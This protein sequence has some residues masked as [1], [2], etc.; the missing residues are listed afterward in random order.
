MGPA[1]WADP[2]KQGHGY[3]RYFIIN[4]TGKVESFEELGGSADEDLDEWH[5]YKIAIRPDRYVEF[6]K[7]GEPI[8]KT[9]SK[10]SLDYTNMPL[11][12]G[13]RS[14]SSYG[15]A[16][17]DN[18]RV[19]AWNIITL[20]PIA[21]FTY[22]P[23]KPV[24][25]QPVI[26]DASRSYDPDGGNITEYWWN[27]SGTVYTAK[28]FNHTFTT[29][30]LKY[31][32][33]EVKDDEGEINSTIKWINVAPS[34]VV[35]PAVLGLKHDKP[36]NVEKG[37]INLLKELGY[38]PIVIGLDQV[39]NDTVVL[40]DY[41]VIIVSTYDPTINEALESE[42]VKKAIIDASNSG[43]NRILFNSGSKVLEVLGLATVRIN[44]P[45]RLGSCATRLLLCC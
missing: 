28:K 27:V 45:S 40:S 2:D 5:T 30:G 25:N 26:F 37:M 41:R 36:T 15:P 8:Y 11:V 22:S 42:K 39:E 34:V 4:E 21:S 29:P 32:Y 13:A 16:L 24:V 6:Y 19:Y 7:D 18:V 38:T 44:P 12:L 10:V 43:T 31:V 23:Q 3:R 9:K 14:H 20:S 33:L 35:Q 1:C 17:H